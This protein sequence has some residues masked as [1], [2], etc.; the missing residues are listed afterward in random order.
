MLELAH[1][2]QAIAAIQTRV[3]TM[4]NQILE[5][6]Q[7]IQELVTQNETLRQENAQLQQQLPQTVTM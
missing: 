1:L 3:D 5:T 7:R 2:P 6:T 4:L